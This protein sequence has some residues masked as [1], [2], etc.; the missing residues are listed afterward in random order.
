[1][2]A[3]DRL[4]GKTLLV[5]S[6][7]LFERDIIEKLIKTDKDIVLVIDGSFKGSKERQKKLESNDLVLVK[8]EKD[9]ITGDRV[10]RKERDNQIIEIG[11]NIDP[12]K[13][14]FEYIGIAFFSEKGIEDLKRSYE[15]DKAA[16]SSGPYGEA[17]NFEMANLHDLLMKMIS[18]GYGIYGLEIHKGW[19]EVHSFEDYKRVSRMLAE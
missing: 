3:K 2:Q 5:Y 17:K 12:K 9:P 8:A 6:D 15:E 19:T 1:M 7:I 13:A 18:K 14:N 11:K 16:Y 10:I 4:E